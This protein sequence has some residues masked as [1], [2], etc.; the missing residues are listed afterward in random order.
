MGQK[1]SFCSNGTRSNCHLGT[2][3]DE[4]NSGRNSLDRITSK[5]TISMY[6]FKLSKF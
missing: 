6:N 2:A 1:V 5:K 4:A 3:L